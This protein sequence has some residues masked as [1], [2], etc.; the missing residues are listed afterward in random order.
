MGRVKAIIVTVGV[1]GLFWWVYE[2]TDMYA[3]GA[4][5]I[6]SG[7]LTVAGMIFSGLAFYAFLRFGKPDKAALP[8]RKNQGYRTGNS[9]V[10]QR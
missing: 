7:Y 8:E 1:M 4:H 3:F 10:Y 2:L 6:L 5:E 9:G